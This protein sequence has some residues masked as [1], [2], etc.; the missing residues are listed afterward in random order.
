MATSSSSTADSP[1]PF[2]GARIVIVMGVS[3]SG[4][5]V[6]G[7]EIA[8][9]LHAPFLDGDDYHPTANV[10]KMSAGIPLTDEDRWP[11]LESL[12]RALHEAADRKGVAV[13]ACSALRRA[14]RDF[15]TEKAEEPIV[16]V[17]LDGS[18][19]LID[20]RI[21]AR[22]GHFMPESLLRSQFATLEPPAPDENAIA[23]PIVEAP[24]KIAALALKQLS[25]LKAFKRGQ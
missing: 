14:Y 5:T 12:A 23:V 21:K 10:K 4:K 22:K 3:A 15:L 20:S 11:W 13:G 8:R 1:Q 17:Y 18:Y 6:V 24:D 16:F 2:D 9:R 19:E 25:Y 7:E